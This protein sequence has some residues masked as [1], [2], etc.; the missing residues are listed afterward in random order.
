MV[1]HTTERHPTLLPDMGAQGSEFDHVAFPGTE[2]RPQCAS[3]GMALGI[4]FL[5]IFGSGVATC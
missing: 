5:A 2:S 4:G 1:G 3:E